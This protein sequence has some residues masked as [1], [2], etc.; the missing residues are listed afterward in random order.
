MLH[1][2]RSQMLPQ[3]RDKRSRQHGH[4]IPATLGI[5]NR[6]FATVEIHVLDPEFGTLQ[7]AKT[8]SVQERGHE[9]CWAPES[10][11]HGRHLLETMR[12]HAD[13]T[14]VADFILNRPGYREARILIAAENF[15]CGSSRENA[16][17]AVA[18]YGI[19]VVIAPSFGDIFFG[20]C[21]QN[22]VLPIR[23][24]AD[25]VDRLAAAALAR[26]DA[27]VLRV[28]LD[29]QTIRT[30]GGETIGFEVEPLR[31]RM[32]L[33]GLDEIGLTLAQAAAIADFQRRDRLLRPWLYA[34][35]VTAR[36]AA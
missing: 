23:L 1:L 35:P 34:P 14:P 30:A 36:P 24:S 2:H 21:F 13:G 27:A 11:E 26:L 17:W 18:S 25:V 31:R 3:R 29:A 5:A 4:P 9:P 8:G 12:F 15:G 19:R 7:Q 16:V 6:E 28:D 33:E 32:L 22:G 10:R 20:N